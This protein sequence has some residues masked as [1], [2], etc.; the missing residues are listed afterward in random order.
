MPIM[1]HSL[2]ILSMF[3]SFNSMGQHIPT[4][5]VEATDNGIIVT[6]HFSGGIQQDDP[7]HPG[8]KFWQI[9]GFALN[10]V[11][12]QP[13]FPFHGDTFVT[14][15]D[16]EVNVDLLDSTFTDIPFTMAPAYPPLLM[17][18]TIGYTPERVPNITNYSGCHY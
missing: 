17:S 9:P 18:D 5:Y 2:F 1:R 8:A 15:D 4:R 3:L 10:D 6:Y 16:C 12:G 13:A 11:A 7:L 14:P